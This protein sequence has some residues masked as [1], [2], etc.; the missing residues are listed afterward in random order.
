MEEIIVEV[1]ANGDVRVEGKGIKGH[2]CTAL[3]KAIE[4]ALGTVASRKLTAEFRAAA[5]V[6]RKA[7]A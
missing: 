2:G 7:G 5:P 3:T 1:A 6:L 4:E